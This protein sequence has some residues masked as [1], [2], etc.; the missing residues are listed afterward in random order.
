MSI[1]HI[2][3]SDETRQNDALRVDSKI[4]PIQEFF[5]MFSI[6]GCILKECR[7]RFIY[8]NFKD[9]RTVFASRHR[10]YNVNTQKCKIGGMFYEIFYYNFLSETTPIPFLA[11]VHGNNK[12]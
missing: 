9:N 8:G 4:V 10:K 5:F 1:R 3:L 7:G 12:Q 6:Y 11:D 2:I